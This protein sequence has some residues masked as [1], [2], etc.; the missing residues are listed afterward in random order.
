MGEDLL[1]RFSE[2]LALLVRG[3]LVQR[4]GNGLGFGAAAQLFRWSPI[5]AARVERIEDDVA[6]FGIVEPL[7][8]LAGRIIDDGRMASLL[9]L[10]EKLHDEPGLAR[11]GV[12]HQLDVL[13]FGAPGNAHE[14]L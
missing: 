14:L 13:P 10:H 6:A 2:E 8:E 12:A 7:H 3:R 9:D 5:G 1:R 11:A 4:G